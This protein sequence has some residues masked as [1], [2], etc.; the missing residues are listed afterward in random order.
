MLVTL[1]GAC[2]PHGI[3]SASRPRAGD[4]GP[5]TPGRTEDTGS[6]RDVGITT[7]GSE[8][9]FNPRADGDSF[10]SCANARDNWCKKTDDYEACRGTGF[11][12]GDCGSYKPIDDDRKSFISDC[13]RADSVVLGENTCAKA[14]GDA[15]DSYVNCLLADRPKTYCEAATVYRV[16]ILRG[17]G[18]LCG[19]ASPVYEACRT[20]RPDNNE[21]PRHICIEGNAE[22]EICR[23]GWGVTAKADICIAA[24]AAYEDCRVRSTISR[25]EARRTDYAKENF[26]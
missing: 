8:A 5:V 1:V 7:L 21:I 9:S 17:S 3:D 18:D 15:S 11:K 26:G 12:N 6:P 2:S 16:C 4:H 24:T 19:D 13:R 22:Y 25:C 20:R 23:N 14:A 10:E